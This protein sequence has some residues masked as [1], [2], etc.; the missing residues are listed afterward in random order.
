MAFTDTDGM[1]DTF[2]DVSQRTDFTEGE[3]SY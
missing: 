1:G 3:I 2:A